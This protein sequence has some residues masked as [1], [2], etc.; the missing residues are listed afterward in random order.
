MCVNISMFTVTLFVCPTCRLARH[1]VCKVRTTGYGPYT[2]EVTQD[3]YNLT[4]GRGYSLQ[5]GRRH[6]L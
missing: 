2:E 1:C 6:G 4:F 3:I 5:R